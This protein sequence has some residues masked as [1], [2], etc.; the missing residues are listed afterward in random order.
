MRITSIAQAHKTTKNI[1]AIKYQKYSF[2]IKKNIVL[3]QPE[4]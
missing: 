1:E 2:Q 3:L 4:F